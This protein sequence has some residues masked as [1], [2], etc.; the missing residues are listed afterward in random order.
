MKKPFF[1]K[2]LIGMK[3]ENLTQAAGGRPPI[4][5]DK[6]PSDNEESI[7]TKYPSDTDEVITNKYPSDGDDNPTIE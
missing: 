7:T 4:I 6:Y 2:F 3:E 1:A 5:T